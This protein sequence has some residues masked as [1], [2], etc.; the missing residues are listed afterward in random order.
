MY[1]ATHINSEDEKEKLQKI[2]LTQTS[3]MDIYF[4]SAASFMYSYSY[5]VY[6][7]SII[8]YT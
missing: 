4:D 5:I 2:D 3:H 1:I 6:R 8:L 7:E